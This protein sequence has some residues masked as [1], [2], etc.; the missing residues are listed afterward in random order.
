V[1]RPWP[2]GSATGVGSLPGTDPLEG[3]RW[4]LGE[5]ALPHIPE[6]PGRGAHADLAGRGAA[7][8]TDLPV[9]LQPTGWRMVPRP[10]R[11][12]QRAQDLLARDLDA[13]EQAAADSPPVLLKAQVT[14]PWTLAASIELNRGD[15]VLADYGAVADLAQSLANGIEL[16]LA[17][18][19]RRFPSTTLLLQVDEPGLTGVLAA[20][21]PTASGFGRLRAPAPQ[22]ARERLATVLAGHERVAVHCCARRPP[23]RLL[24]EAGATALSLDAAMLDGRDDDDLGAA[25]EQ[26]VGLL[27]GVV[28]GSDAELPSVRD[29]V[30][31]LGRLRDRVGLDPSA[32]VLTP[33]CGLAGAAPDYAR[34]ALA[35]CVEAAG[36]AAAEEA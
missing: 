1:S 8:L 23:V 6:L 31:L 17:D 29:V 21:I 5:L 30:E 34:A 7:L 10:S 22:L 15:R 4:V 18:L 33:S 20:Q 32:T 3:A 36:A 11:D 35:R 28:P 25:L 19:Q 13:F 12:G 27:L 24:V 16:H 26:G 2:D 9:D 14:G